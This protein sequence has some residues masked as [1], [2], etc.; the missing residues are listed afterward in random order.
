MIRGE[1]LCWSGEVTGDSAEERSP[2]AVG[3]GSWAGAGRDGGDE[4][5][6][7]QPRERNVL[8]YEGGLVQG[9]VVG[10]FS[11]NGTQYNCCTDTRPLI[12]GW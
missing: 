10:N 5:H 9:M 12:P 3:E 4:G 2:P 6:V 8:F 11:D 7:D 1:L